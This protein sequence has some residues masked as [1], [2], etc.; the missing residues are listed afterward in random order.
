MYG[1]SAIKRLLL[2]KTLALSQTRFFEAQT[3]SL[4]EDLSGQ[5][6]ATLRANHHQQLIPPRTPKARVAGELS[7]R[8]CT[9][10]ERYPGARAR[11]LRQK[12]AHTERQPRPR[13]MDDDALAYANKAEAAPTSK[14]KLA[15]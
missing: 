12:G 13:R 9:L 3:T 15:S 4:S 2:A 14:L 10:R 5:A 1:T 7:L 6:N 8:A 11:A